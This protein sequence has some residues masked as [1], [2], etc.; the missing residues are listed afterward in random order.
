M[1]QDFNCINKTRAEVLK[2]VFAVVYFGRKKHSS[3]QFFVIVNLL[4]IYR[5][6]YD[7]GMLQKMIPDKNIGPI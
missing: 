3:F 7:K 1:G 5:Y 6:T 2:S 4:R